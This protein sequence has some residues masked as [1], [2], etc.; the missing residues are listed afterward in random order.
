MPHCD[1]ESGDPGGNG[2]GGRD[3][4]DGYFEG[5]PDAVDPACTSVR[6]TAYQASAGGWC[7]FDRTLP[8]LPDFVLDGMTTAIAEPWN[9][10]SYGGDVGEACGECWEVSNLYE[11]QVVMVHDLCPIEGNPLCSG[12]HFHFDL[13]TEAG[14]ALQGGGL[15]AAVARRVP[16]PVTGNIHVQ[17]N[18]WNEWGYLRLAFVN[19]RIPIRAA[20]VRAAPAGD[21]RPMKRS[22][23]AWDILD[24]PVPNDGDGVVFR[25]TS[26]AGEV[27]EGT[28]PI[29][30]LDASAYT[31]EIGAQ[32]TDP[33]TPPT[34]ECAFTPPGDVYDD[35]FGGID[36]VRWTMNPWGN[37]TWDEASEGCYNGSASCIRVRDMEQWGGLHIYYNQG[38]PPQTFTTLTLA[39][40]AVSGNG[41]LT[42]APSYEGERC[43]EQ[44]VSITT[45][46]WSEVTIPLADSCADFDLIS[47]VTLSNRTDTLTFLIDAVWFE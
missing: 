6:L 17:I 1:K 46:A 4:N 2:G 14:A 30:F 32:F 8:F 42:V 47:A 12:W 35:E 23:G 16:C 5:E 38:F 43:T 31:Q 27:I 11:T 29:P 40:K 3:V 34:G 10:S 18:D 39:L 33:E 21:W 15:D 28:S 13:S 9:N 7:E 20:E 41:E 44:A 22:G 26:A 24:G 37:A 19:H 36:S 45:D 25:L